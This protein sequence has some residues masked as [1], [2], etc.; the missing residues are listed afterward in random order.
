[1]TAR[2]ARL[3]VPM[4]WGGMLLSAL[5]P[6]RIG[7]PSKKVRPA[8]PAWIHR[9][10]RR[11]GRAAQPNYVLTRTEPVQIAAV[12][13]HD[14]RAARQHGRSRDRAAVRLRAGDERA[15]VARQEM[16]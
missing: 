11:P 2:A 7:T 13:L 9:T 8:K 12:R 15:V 3:A 14:P 5:V 16:H 4:M 6:I 1:M 10:T